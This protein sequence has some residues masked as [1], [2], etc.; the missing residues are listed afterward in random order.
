VRHAVPR[1][2][3]GLPV[4]GAGEFHFA[5]RLLAGEVCPG[6]VGRTVKGDLVPAPTRHLKSPLADP[7]LLARS[8]AQCGACKV[9]Q[10]LGKV[11]HQL[12]R[13]ARRGTREEFDEC[14]SWTPRKTLAFDALI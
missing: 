7:A 4:L 13:L 2:D 12:R 8:K 3:H 9:W 14:E 6:D 11:P 1:E 5:A 10:F